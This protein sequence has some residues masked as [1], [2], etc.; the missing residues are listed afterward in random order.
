MKIIHCADIHLGSK[1]ESKF[2]KEISDKRKSELLNTF[3]RMIDYAK[4]NDIKIILLSGDIFDKDK[5]IIKDKEFFYNAIKQNSDIDFLYLKGNHDIEGAYFES[6][7][8]LKTFNSDNFITYSYDN[9]DITGIELSS[10]NEKSFYSKLN[11]NKDK[12]NIVMLHGEATNT[13]GKDKIKLDNLKNKGIDY[14]ALGHIH[15]YKS[16]LIDERGTYAYSGCLEPR[17]FDECGDKGFIELDITDK[18][19]YKFIPFSK[20]K[21]IEIDVDISKAL[22]LY[23]AISIIKK[24][25]SLIEKSNIL[26]INLIGELTLGLEI[27]TNDIKEALSDYF[28]LDVKNKTSIMI[29]SSKY[30]NDKSL[31]GVFVKNI[32]N[33]NDYTEEEKKKLINMGLNAI[34]GKDILIWS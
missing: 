30:E 14:L 33:N 21:I 34:N 25:T 22:S 16:G 28:F 18:V 26:R 5:P 1:L 15:A 32:L 12:I 10:K 9:I 23:S 4:D 7:P 19:N 8:N 31:I 11:L 27:D 17:G 24:E 20:R 6:I 2:S 13:T 3:S 29:D